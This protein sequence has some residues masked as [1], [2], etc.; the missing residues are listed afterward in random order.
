MVIGNFTEDIDKDLSL[1]GVFNCSIAYIVQA[2]R[3]VDMTASYSFKEAM[4]AQ[5]KQVD[6]SRQIFIRNLLTISYFRN[7][8]VS[9]F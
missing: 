2:S 7:H 9:T 3:Y 6:S 8:L 1:S 5:H 4:S